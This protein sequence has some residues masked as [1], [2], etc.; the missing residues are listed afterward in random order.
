[1]IFNLSGNALV[2]AGFGGATFVGAASLALLSARM[3][4]DWL[5]WA[6][7]LVVALLVVNAFVQLVGGETASDA[8]GIGS[9]LAFVAWLVAASTLLSR[10]SA[11]AAAAPQLGAESA[12]VAATGP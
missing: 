7:G 6:G 1:M 12:S 5:A 3:L 10:W 8:L 2:L 11:R 9:F 4:A